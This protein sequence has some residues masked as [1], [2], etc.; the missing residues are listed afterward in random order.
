MDAERFAKGF[1]RDPR[2]YARL[3][4]K[5][6]RNARDAL[7]DPPVRWS[8]FFSHLT[9]SYLTSGKLDIDDVNKNLSL[10]TGNTTRHLLRNISETTERA[11]FY[12]PALAPHLN[13][14]NFHTI[15]QEMGASWR[16]LLDPEA[17]KPL[18]Y[19]HLAAIQAR[20]SV[21]ALRLV[22][23]RRDFYDQLLSTTPNPTNN[24][25]ALDQSFVGRIT[26]IDASIALLQVVKQLPFDEVDHITVL[27]AP[28]KYEGSSGNASDFLLLDTKEWQAHGIQV[29]TRLYDPSQYNEEFVS[30]IDGIE[31][32]GNYKLKEVSGRGPARQ[33]IPG[34]IAA[35]YILHSEDLGRYSSFSRLPEF[36]GTFGPI[37]HAREIAQTMKSHMDYTDR[38]T[39]A[40]NKIGARLIAALREN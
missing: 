34:L 7:I 38:A 27:P 20:L 40:A 21:H 31:D 13:R 2:E 5:E 28:S 10:Y 14:M 36:A 18:D 22:E 9:D 32:L 6:W 15:N 4:G 23:S 35:D 16:H 12:K 3:S 19:I 26:E 33:A 37:Y 39:H 29:K 17:N 24:D 8:H 1:E 25:L 30:F 11:A